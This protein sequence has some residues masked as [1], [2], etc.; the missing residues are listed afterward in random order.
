MLSLF[1]APEGHIIVLLMLKGRAIVLLILKGGSIVLLM[2]EGRIIVLLHR[3]HHRPS[4]VRRT[5][6]RGPARRGSPRGRAKRP[7]LCGSPPAGA[8][9]INAMER[10][11]ESESERAREGDRER[12]RESEGERAREEKRE[13]AGDRGCAPAWL[14]VCKQIPHT[15]PAMV[16][17]DPSRSK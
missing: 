10:Q 12:G 11:K 5:R 17:L 8:R 3:T 14:F 6:R 7:P 2:L 16:Q 4:N 9:G 13:R 1:H 15:Q